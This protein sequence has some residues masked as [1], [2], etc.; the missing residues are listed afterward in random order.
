LSRR[1]ARSWHLR[2]PGLLDRLAG[3]AI[4]FVLLE[5]VILYIDRR[6]VPLIAHL[7]CRPGTAILFCASIS[8]GL[9]RATAFHPAFQSDYRTW[10]QSTPWTSRKP[11]PMGPIELVWEDGM[12]LAS[13]ILLAAT[14][15]EPHA[16]QLLCAFLLA[17]L[18]GLSFSF[19]LTRTRAPGYATAFGLGLAVWLWRQ[20]VACLVAATLVYLIADEGLWQAL[21]SF[22][23]EPWK[24][25][26]LTSEMTSVDWQRE[27]CGWPYDRMLGEVIELREIS[28]IDALLGCMLGSGWLY[29][30]ASLLGDPKDRSAVMLLAV[31]PAALSPL[32]R[33][34]VYGYVYMYPISFWARIWTFRWIIPGYDQIFIAPLCSLL[35][36]PMTGVFLYAW[37][38]PVEVCLPVASGVAV[39][40]ALVTPP[41]LRRWR[42]TGQHR[43]V[44]VA[45]VAAGQKYVAVG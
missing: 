18:L 9:S 24:L 28:R 13:L 43:L 19:L 1:R 16:V 14:L 39:L 23:W 8:Y 40:V 2:I 3:I 32:F 33:L 34:I 29:V 11:L 27:D 12:F 41:R 38:V 26:R 4:S 45:T 36:G 7:P 37:G 30:L 10:L 21:R 20:P 22:P 35:A 31:L 6:L 15:P 17:H 5:G 25:P 44:P 42:L